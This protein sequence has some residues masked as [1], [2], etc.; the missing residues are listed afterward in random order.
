[1]A[2]R[3]RPPLAT[4]RWKWAREAADNLPADGDHSHHLASGAAFAVGCRLPAS[5]SPTHP[6][7]PLGKGRDPKVKQ[8][9]PGQQDSATV[10]VRMD[11]SLIG[12]R[13]DMRHEPDR[14]R[15]QGT[16]GRRSGAAP[17]EATWRS[18]RRRLGETETRERRWRRAAR[19][20]QCAGVFG[21]PA[22]RHHRSTGAR[23]QSSWP[24][25]WG[26]SVGRGCRV[27]FPQGRDWSRPDSCRKADPSPTHIHTHACTPHHTC[28]SMMSALIISSCYCVRALRCPSACGHASSGARGWPC[29]LWHW[30]GMDPRA[31][32][33]MR[34]Q[35]CA[36]S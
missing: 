12:G 30:L 33:A 1:M 21:A 29:P 27:K 34:R 31:C 22:R 13:R 11:G 26:Q 36:S 19:V 18:G 7:C 35:P 16:Q 24:T 4:R 5:P 10:T 3:F 17:R 6:P 23:G 15:R 14:P 28:S 20:A 8:G 9:T 32:P 2:W 25:S